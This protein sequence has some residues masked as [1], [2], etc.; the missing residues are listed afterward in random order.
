MILTQDEINNFKTLEDYKI[1]DFIIE[2]CGSV[3]SIINDF[4]LPNAEIAYSKYFIRFD[5]YRSLSSMIYQYKLG[6]KNIPQ[7]F[8]YSI[9]KIFGFPISYWD[10]YQ[11]M[12]FSKKIIYTNKEIFIKSK[13]ILERIEFNEK[14]Y[15]SNEK[16][17]MVHI[18]IFIYKGL[19]ENAEKLLCEAINKY[20]QK[21]EFFFKLSFL[22]EKQNNFPQREIYYKFYQKCLK[23]QYNHFIDTQNLYME[24][25]LKGGN[26]IS[27]DFDK[28]IYYTFKAI[29]LEPTLFF[30][31][32]NL[33]SILVSSEKPINK[34]FPTIE[35]NKIFRDNA[36]AKIIDALIIIFEKIKSGI[37]NQKNYKIKIDK[38]LFSWNKQYKYAFIGNFSINEF[39]NSNDYNIQEQ[40]KYTALKLKNIRS[41]LIIE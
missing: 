12:K 24:Y 2:K 40:L 13:N 18:D 28:S 7:Y 32:N 6:M 29:E 41:E 10:F 33:L 8:K 27:E 37:F 9:S 15:L 35:F 36:E 11:N 22:Y 1:L 23:K 16:E 3:N 39:L 26:L 19:I 25:M 20:P 17:Y 21:C 30:A 4:L 14:N 5:D 31:Y 34:I 38:L